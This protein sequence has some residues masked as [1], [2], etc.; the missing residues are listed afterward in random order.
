MTEDSQNRPPQSQPPRGPAPKGS[1]KDKWIKI[2]F[3]VVF[4]AAIVLIY[5]H[6]LEGPSAPQ[7]WEQDVEYGMEIAR[8]EGRPAV[9]FFHARHP[10][11][12]ARHILRRA[13]PKEQVD[14]AIAR[15]EYVALLAIVE[16]TDDELARQY[17]VTQ[18]PA[19]VV[20]DKRGNVVASEQGKRIG[21]DELTQLLDQAAENA[22]N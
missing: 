9:I 10:S 6:Q 12:N 21:H 5:L 11:E 4:L 8:Q 18:L 20:L 22:A 17:N 1:R 7:G 2:G 13:L 16:D 14:K 3:G 19:F 15:S